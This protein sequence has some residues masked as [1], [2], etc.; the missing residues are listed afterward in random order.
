MSVRWMRT[1]QIANGKFMEAIAWAKETAGYVEK[2]WGTPHVAVLLD[3]FGPVGMVRWSTDFADLA[4]VEKVQAQMMMDQTYWQMIDKA[5]KAE[6]FV[7]GTSVDTI[8][9]MV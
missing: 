4:A 9:R 8:S 1:A 7:D 2:K 5:F 3:V 6:L